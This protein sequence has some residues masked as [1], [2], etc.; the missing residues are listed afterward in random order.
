MVFLEG[1]VSKR[2]REKHT[3]DICEVERTTHKPICYIPD[4]CDVEFTCKKC[5]D[6]FCCECCTDKHILWGTNSILLTDSRKGKQ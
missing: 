3:C 1:K 4:D 2:F 5:H 6:E